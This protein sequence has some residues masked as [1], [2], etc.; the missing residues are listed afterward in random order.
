MAKSDYTFSISVKATPEQVFKNIN[1]VSKW[2][3]E[4]VQGRSEEL[5][6]EF[7]IHNL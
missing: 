2:W 7:I 3:T 1:S 4:N 5:N 6:D